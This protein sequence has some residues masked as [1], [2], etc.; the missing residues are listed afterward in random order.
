MSFGSPNEAYLQTYLSRG[1]R[2]THEFFKTFLNNGHDAKA[3]LK[4]H[5]T[6][7]YVYCQ[8]GKDDYLPW[9]IVDHGYRNNF[10]WE[11]YQR[12]LNAAHTPICDTAICHICGLC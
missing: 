2:S 7:R 4:K 12:G 8:Y 11:D 9:D 6:D 3:A 10:L 1:D 5:S